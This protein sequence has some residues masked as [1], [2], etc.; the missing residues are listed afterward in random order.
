MSTNKFVAAAQGTL[1]DGTPAT[2]QVTQVGLLAN[3]G[4]GQGVA[5]GFPAERVTLSPH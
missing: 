4:Q 5:D 3:P 2:R 1:A